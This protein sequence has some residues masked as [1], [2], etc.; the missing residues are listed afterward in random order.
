MNVHFGIASMRQ[1]Q[2]VPTTYFTE[3]KEMDFE[4]YAKQVSYPLVFLF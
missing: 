4:I 2:R 1:F 3:I